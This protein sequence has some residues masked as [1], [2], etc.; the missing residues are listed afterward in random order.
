M[1]MEMMLLK[2][3]FKNLTMWFMSCKH[4]GAAMPLWFDI[5]LEFAHASCCNFLKLNA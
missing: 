2:G 4:G 3:H 1:S 5:F